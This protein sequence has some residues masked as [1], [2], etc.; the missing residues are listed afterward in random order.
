M[1]DVG[2]TY[3]GATSRSRACLT[4]TLALTRLYVLGLLRTQLL[5]SLPSLSSSEAKLHESPLHFISS[6]MTA[7]GKWVY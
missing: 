5:P 4:L 3:Y 6:R 7:V 1:C 2:S